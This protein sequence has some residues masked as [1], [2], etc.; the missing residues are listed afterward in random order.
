MG[1]LLNASD[2]SI[3]HL[4]WKKRVINLL[5][6]WQLAY[7]FSLK[8]HALWS[9]YRKWPFLEWRARRIRTGVIYWSADEA[10]LMPRLL[11]TPSQI[12]K[13]RYRSD[14]NIAYRRIWC[15]LNHIWFISAICNLAISSIANRQFLKSF[16]TV[17]PLLW[18]DVVI[19]TR[20]GCACDAILKGF[21]LSR[22]LG[23]FEI[24]KKF[25]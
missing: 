2:K 7:L 10:W 11:I 8:A 3:C 19:N 9:D 17:V 20:V 12:E 1:D 16:F 14:R 15:P 21:F 25:S 18:C 24:S 6:N 13:V 4:M 22:T 5:N 23:F